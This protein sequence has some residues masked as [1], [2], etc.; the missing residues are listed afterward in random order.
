MPSVSSEK[1]VLTLCKVSFSYAL[2]SRYYIV[3]FSH[4]IFASRFAS[5]VPSCMLLSVIVPIVVVTF[6]VDFRS[7]LPKFLLQFS[8][9]IGFVLGGERE[10]QSK[11]NFTEYNTG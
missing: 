8:G 5:F 10:R 2:I 11:M 9:F 1:L 4:E 3:I 6:H 7:R